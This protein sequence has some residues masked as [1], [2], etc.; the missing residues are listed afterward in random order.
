M[1]CC[2]F[3]FFKEV[4]WGFFP[5]SKVE[6]PWNTDWTHLCLTESRLRWSHPFCLLGVNRW[7]ALADKCHTKCK[8][9]ALF[10][11]LWLF[12]P[13]VLCPSA[14][15][16]HTVS[17][18]DDDDSVSLGCVFVYFLLQEAVRSAHG[19]SWMAVFYLED[20]HQ[21]ASSAVSRYFSLCKIL[22]LVFR[23][24]S[25]HWETGRLI[26]MFGWWLEHFQVYGVNTCCLI[27][28]VRVS[29]GCYDLTRIKQLLKT[30]W[31]TYASMCVWVVCQRDQ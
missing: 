30:C 12:W 24:S 15:T 4:F 18:V 16:E 17:L 11:W 22:L 29:R 3:V 26:G 2:L 27:G 6:S 10:L 19:C 13:F 31:R 28:K 5:P 20:F 21:S 1:F 7:A 25:K 14:L 9:S 23:L 8:Y